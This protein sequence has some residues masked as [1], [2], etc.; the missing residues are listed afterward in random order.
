MGE[1]IKNY[2]RQAGKFSY[3]KHNYPD[4]RS[5]LFLKYKSCISQHDASYMDRY[6]TCNFIMAYKFLTLISI[7]E[8]KICN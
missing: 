7:I 4:L 5:N 3:K 1:I 6:K 8:V 2:T